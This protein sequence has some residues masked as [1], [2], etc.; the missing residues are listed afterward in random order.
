MS[1]TDE[2][3]R[4]GQEIWTRHR[5]ITRRRARS[6]GTHLSE[7]FSGGKGNPFP[8]GNSEE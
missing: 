5:R 7:E 4:T 8:P 6:L 1:R 3:I 2:T